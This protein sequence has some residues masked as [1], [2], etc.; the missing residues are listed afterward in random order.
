MTSAPD[1][2]QQFFQGCI[3]QSLRKRLSPEDPGK[4]LAAKIQHDQPPTPS[5]QCRNLCNM[6][7]L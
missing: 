2:C 1:G 6:L 7:A 3:K 5:R 4:D